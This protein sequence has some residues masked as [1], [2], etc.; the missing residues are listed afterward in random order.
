M[1]LYEY[2]LNFTVAFKCVRYCLCFVTPSD[3]NIFR[4]LLGWSIDGS[5][6]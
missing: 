1:E 6:V 5:S 2:R 4:S 3:W